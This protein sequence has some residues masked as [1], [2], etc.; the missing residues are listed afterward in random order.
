M[1]NNYKVVCNTA[2]G[3]RRYMQYLIPFIVSNN[4]VDR[5]DIWINTTNKQDIEFFRILSKKFTKI[6]LVYQP[7]GIV[8]G[9]RS[10]NAFYQQCIEEDTIYF[11]LDDDIIWLE[12]DAIEKMVTFRVD[13]PAYF[14]VSPLVINNAICTYILQNTG[15]LNLNQYYQAKAD[16]EI[17]WK[18]GNFAVELHEW[19]LKKNL[20]NGAYNNLHCGIHPIA[21]NRFSINAILW[22][23][24]EMKK[25]EGIVPGDDEEWLSVVKPSELGITNCINGDAIVSHFAFYTQRDLLD[26]C[27]ILE[28]YGT[29]LHKEWSKNE[30][31]SNIDKIVQDVMI[32][33]EK[34]KIEIEN[35]PA[36]YQEFTNK[37]SLK[38]R[39]GL[40]KVPLVKLYALGVIRNR[41]INAFTKNKKNTFIFSNK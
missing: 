1:I 7:D 25:F 29:F 36:I 23:G 37:I 9:N 32:D 38:K 34:R 17:L 22:F 19:F 11:K 33:V 30:S 10:I 6:N 24:N 8:N 39:I 27:N 13:N 16:H 21:M 35:M 12:S 15:K 2:A 18:N 40:L 41:L 5:Y 14:I 20:I 31:L 3:R 4:I 28:Y 26:K